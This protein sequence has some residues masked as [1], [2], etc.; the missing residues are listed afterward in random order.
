[1]HIFLAKPFCNLHHPLLTRCSKNILSK[2]RG[3]AKRIEFG[4]VV[5]F[6]S[7]LSFP[8]SSVGVNWMLEQGMIAKYTTVRFLGTVFNKH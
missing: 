8:A 6:L 1:M 2:M 4:F 7:Y 5:G 3:S